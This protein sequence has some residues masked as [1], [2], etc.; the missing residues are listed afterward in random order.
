MVHQQ[1]NY[2]QLFDNQWSIIFYHFRAKMSNSPQFHFVNCEDFLVVCDSK[3]IIVWIS[4]DFRVLVEQN[5]TI[6]WHGVIHFSLF[7]DILSTKRF[8]IYTMS[9]VDRDIVR[10]EFVH[11]DDTEVFAHFSQL[12]KHCIILFICCCGKQVVSS[13]LILIE[14]STR[15]W[16][17]IFGG[18]LTK[19]GSINISLQQFENVAFLL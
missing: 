14:T 5:K 15:T 13:Q 2:M 17:E 7:S 1:K 8:T 12:P 4:M 9:R 3:L 10:L 6:W 11:K 19:S 16:E 18:R